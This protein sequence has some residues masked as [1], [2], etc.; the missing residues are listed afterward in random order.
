MMGPAPKF[1]RQNL[2]DHMGRA[3]ASGAAINLPDFK[4]THVLE[5]GKISERVRS[6]GRVRVGGKFRAMA[7]SYVGP[8]KALAVF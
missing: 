6:R 5:R 7:P 3:P 2:V 4:K 8:K 1:Q